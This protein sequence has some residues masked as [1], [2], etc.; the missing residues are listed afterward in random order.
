MPRQPKKPIRKR[1]LT[2][3]DFTA[4][5]RAEKILQQRRY[6]EMFEQWRRCT[7]GRC[8][9]EQRCMGDVSACLKRALAAVPHETQWQAREKIFAATARNIGAPE[10]AARQCMPLDLYVDG[11][12]EA[13]R[14]Y[15]ARFERKRPPQRR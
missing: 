1:Q 9:R 2:A 8:H 13:I 15:L 10:R 7:S 14:E 12:A 11:S 3:A 6:C 5:Y 4:R